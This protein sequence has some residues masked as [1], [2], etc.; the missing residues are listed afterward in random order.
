MELISDEGHVESCFGPFGDVVSV[1][2]RLV[3]GLHQ[4]YHRLRNRFGYT[5]GYSS[6]T[7]LNWK[8]DS[9]YLVIVLILTQ[10][11][12]MVCTERTISSEIFFD[13]TDRIPR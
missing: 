12:P 9:V 8:L 4:T 5:R 3:Q 10:D 6:V 2:A 11:R 1:G 13:T 7:R